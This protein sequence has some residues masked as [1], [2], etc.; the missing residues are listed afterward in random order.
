[1]AILGVSSLLLAGTAAMW[2]IQKTESTSDKPA[3][4]TQNQGIFTE[5]IT[6]RT[7]VTDFAPQQSPDSIQ[8]PTE[9]FT[10]SSG[11][12][13]TSVRT[14]K[15][16]ASDGKP[17]TA[18]QSLARD[19]LR[20]SENAEYSAELTQLEQSIQQLNTVSSLAD[21]EALETKLRA[22][23]PIVATGT[24]DAVSATVTLEIDNEPH[25]INP[26]SEFSKT[27]E[28]PNP[29][30]AA[31]PVHAPSH[32][33]D[34]QQSKQHQ[35]TKYSGTLDSWQI[36]NLA[37]GDQFSLPLGT[38]DQATLRI[39]DRTEKADQIL[40]IARPLDSEGS[41]SF[42][43]TITDSGLTFF[44]RIQMETDVINYSSNDGQLLTVVSQST[45]EANP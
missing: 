4:T 18:S 9:F 10:L 39:T 36:Q 16:K 45:V 19:D 7:D 29:Q 2:A 23:V 40:Y 1:M 3:K 35:F 30:D 11:A 13:I 17:E 42:K 32:Q 43:L 12:L 31:R 5:Q 15:Q 14:P 22:H 41:A 44:G 33:L 21:Y 37:I 20:H 25:A 34:Q 24:I 38:A 27:L 26:F 28:A 6:R 8:E